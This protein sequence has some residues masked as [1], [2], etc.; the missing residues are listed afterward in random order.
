MVYDILILF[1]FLKNIILD[2][3]GNMTIPDDVIRGNKI[4]T[5]GIVRLIFCG[6]QQAH[7]QST[8]MKMHLCL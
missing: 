1:S 4:W 5:W 7:A 8:Q 2:F 6:L 3:K